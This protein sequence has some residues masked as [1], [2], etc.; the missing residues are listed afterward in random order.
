MLHARRPPAPAPAAP[1]PAEER[2]RYDLST[3]SVDTGLFPARSWGRLQRDILS[4]NPAL[5][6]RG[7]MQGDAALREQIAAYLNAYRGVVCT[8]EQ[9]VVGAGIEYLHCKYG[10]SL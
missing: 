2:P 5:L 7:E 8:P 4:Q 6:Q 9:V 10:Y 1:A 3:G